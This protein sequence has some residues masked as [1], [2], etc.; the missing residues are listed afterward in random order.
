M[1]HA[2]RYLQEQS[3]TSAPETLYL[4]TKQREYASDHA[5]IIMLVL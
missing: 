2:A 4:Y 5:S 3:L 1:G